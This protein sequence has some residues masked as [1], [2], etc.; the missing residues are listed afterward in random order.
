MPA[1]KHAAASSPAARIIDA[2]RM[3]PPLRSV[4]TLVLVLV[5][6]ASAYRS[7]PFGLVAVPRRAGPRRLVRLALVGTLLVHDDLRLLPARGKPGSRERGDGKRHDHAAHHLVPPV[8]AA[9]GGLGA[10]GRP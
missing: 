3:R 2:L 1:A 10:S 8:G 9:A 5:L 4:D 6:V 7:V